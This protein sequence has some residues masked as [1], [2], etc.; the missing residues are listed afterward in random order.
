MLRH[1]RH[2]SAKT[3][4]SISL[5]SHE[6]QDYGA[7]CHLLTSRVIHEDVLLSSAIMLM[8]CLFS[9]DVIN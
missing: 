6:R 3:N 7:R 4:I 9:C 1:E 2:N 8:R 5:V